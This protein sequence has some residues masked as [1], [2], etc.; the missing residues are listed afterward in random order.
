MMKILS[1]LCILFLFWNCKPNTKTNDAFINETSPSLM[2]SVKPTVNYDSFV[3]KNKDILPFDSKF[4]KITAFAE[5]KDGEKFSLFFDVT[6]QTK[7]FVK[8]ITDDELANIRINQVITPDQ[9]SDG[10]FGK[11]IEFPLYQGGTYQIVIAE[12]LMQGNPFHGKFKVEIE[13]K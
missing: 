3:V 5:K 2:D 10:P 4:N 7:A 13:L 11:E 1:F 9:Q 6:T 12:S 8:I